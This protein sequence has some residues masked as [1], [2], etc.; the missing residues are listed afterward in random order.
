MAPAS[1]GKDSNN[2]NAVIKIAQANRG[3]LW[4]ARF[5]VR[6]LVIVVMKFIAPKIE[7][8]PDKCRLKTAKSMDPPEWAV[9]LESGVN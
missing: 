9:M 5:F 4:K 6:I 2:K 7:E 3:N 8:A 1:T